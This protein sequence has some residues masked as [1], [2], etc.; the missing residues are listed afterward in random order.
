M[1]RHSICAD[2]ASASTDIAL[3]NK[4]CRSQCKAPP[5]PKL[6]GAV[7]DTRA[8]GLHSMI[9]ASW[10]QAWAWPRVSWEE[11]AFVGLALCI[12]QET[13]NGNFQSPYM[14]CL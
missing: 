2:Y 11:G 12:L 8:R 4:L 14:H 5:P 9:Y 1:Y 3:L 7:E 6:R 13:Q 10:H